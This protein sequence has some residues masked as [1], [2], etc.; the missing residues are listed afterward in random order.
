MW[1]LLAII[2]HYHYEYKIRFLFRVL[3]ATCIAHYCFSVIPLFVFWNC[4]INS[5]SKF[6]RKMIS[7]RPND[8]KQRSISSQIQNYSIFDDVKNDDVILAIFAFK[9]YMNLWRILEYYYSI[10]LNNNEQIVIIIE[11]YWYSKNHFIIPFGNNIGAYYNTNYIKTFTISL[12]RFLHETFFFSVESLNIWNMF[13]IECLTGNR[14]C[15]VKKWAF[16][17]NWFFLSLDWL[18][19]LFQKPSQSL[20]ETWS[21]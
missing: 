17:F 1:S 9:I 5:D 21:R 3:G 15:Y 7:K 18:W 14:F 4:R 11:S 19:I 13:N 6:V 8:K 10:H 2:Y 16:S 20:R 12:N